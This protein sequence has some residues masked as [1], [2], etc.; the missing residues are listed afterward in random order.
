MYAVNDD[1]GYTVLFI[2]GLEK[3]NIDTLDELFSKN[4]EEII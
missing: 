3:Q 4:A 2:D 1:S